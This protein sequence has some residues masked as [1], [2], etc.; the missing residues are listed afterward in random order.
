[1]GT[2]SDIDQTHQARA[3]QLAA[4]GVQYAQGGWVDVNGRVKSK[5]AP[6]NDLPNL[7]AGSERYTPRGISGL[8]ELTRNEDE[9]VAVPD[10][11][12]PKVPPWDRRARMAPD[13]M[14]G[15]RSRSRTARAPSSSARLRLRPMP[16]SWTC[17]REG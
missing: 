3:E 4:D 2:V 6:V 9:S 7:L 14:F 5:I 10:V 1:M 8:G 16:G 12:T 13:L 15:V 17:R 11:S